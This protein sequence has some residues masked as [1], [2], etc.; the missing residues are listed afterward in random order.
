MNTEDHFLYIANL[1]QKNTHTEWLLDKEKNRI[2]NTNKSF[3]DYLY[4]KEL[5]II[6]YPDEQSA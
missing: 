3:K 4:Y 2:N 5:L 6:F 1:K